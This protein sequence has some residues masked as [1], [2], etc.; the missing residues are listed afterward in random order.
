[1]AQNGWAFQAGAG[2][3]S[4]R[5]RAG[6]AGV[7]LHGAQVAIP[8]EIS[9][10]RTGGRTSA[11]LRSGSDADWHGGCTLWSRLE[12]KPEGSELHCR[13]TTLGAAWIS[14]SIPGLCFCPFLWLQ[15]GRNCD[16]LTYLC[17]AAGTCELGLAGGSDVGAQQH[18]KSAAGWWSSKSTPAI[19]RTLVAGR[20][21]RW[22]SCD[23][24]QSEGQPAPA[25]DPENLSQALRKKGPQMLEI[26]RPL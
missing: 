18:T 22:H 21:G 25:L 6:H 2:P 16:L 10:L 15:V 9:T 14:H 1:M 7:L 11:A 8:N 23:Q 4:T 24:H 3:V 12:N 17:T 19:F 13:F 5:H 26:R 20:Y